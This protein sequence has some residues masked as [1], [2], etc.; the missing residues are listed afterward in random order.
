MSLINE[1]LKN[2][3]KRNGHTPKQYSTNNPAADEEESSMI[4]IIWIGAVVVF[5]ILALTI[6][7]HYYEKNRA[8][9]TQPNNT[10]SVVNL[11]AQDA[12]PPVVAAKTA[13]IIPPHLVT[14]HQ[15]H[16]DDLPDQTTISLDLSKTTNFTTQADILHN[17]E[18]LT[19]DD[20][21]L[22]PIQLCQQLG[23]A[24]NCLSNGNIPLP[25]NTAAIKSIHI[26]QNDGKHLTL[27]FTL[28]NTGK[29]LDAQLKDNTLKIIF[30]NKADA[31][32]DSSL[33]K[34]SAPLPLP[35][36][37]ASTTQS[38]PDDGSVILQP[39]AETSNAPFTKYDQMDAYIL[40][41]QFD[42]AEEVLHQLTPEEK[43]SKSGLMLAAKLQLALGDN[44]Q[45]LAILNKYPF[46]S[47]NPPP[48]FYALYAA[49]LE[50]N[51]RHGE[52]VNIYKNL[53]KQAPNNST[54]LLGFAIAAQNDHQFA[55]AKSTYQS[56]MNL[57]DL[58]PEITDYA[59][60]QIEKI[61]L[62]N[63]S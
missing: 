25:V 54:W 10:A 19:I 44:A 33:L 55:L 50:F 48:E 26:N 20:T 13:S 38:P 23:K 22:D 63:Q 45:A 27:L 24:E 43:N 52:A 17:T 51:G 59:T 47:K 1:M 37:I 8:H 41:K 6:G 9:H 15:I 39:I 32:T 61:N 3:E 42:K 56:L 4:L 11:A 36:D 14:I 62:E 57:K 58:N 53:V 2:L 28:S 35:S 21:W 16:I 30:T 18:I 49:T 7:V 12:T 29:M 34:A 46:G 60:E 5:I 40:L 31:N